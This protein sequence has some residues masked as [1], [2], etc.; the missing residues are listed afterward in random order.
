MHEKIKDGTRLGSVIVLSSILLFSQPDLSQAQSPNQEATGEAAEPDLQNLVTDEMGID[1]R[2]EA[3]EN[4]TNVSIPVGSLDDLTRALVSL[5]E[6]MKKRNDN[7]KFSIEKALGIVI[8]VL[9]AFLGAVL[10]FLA[11]Q[12]TEKRNWIRS[13]NHAR[14][15]RQFASTASAARKIREA[16]SSVHG[17]DIELGIISDSSS[18]TQV[19]KQANSIELQ[20]RQKQWASQIG[21]VISSIDLTSVELRL[22]DVPSAIC[23][24]LGEFSDRLSLVLQEVRRSP[25]EDF[26]EYAK[27]MRYQVRELETSADNFV[28]AARQLHRGMYE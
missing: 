1:D 10:T 7:A 6:Q 19:E 15:D 21:E 14:R 26:E 13:Q 27:S 23:S 8:P 25:G 17:I 9:A 2:P 16:L 4:A 28:S 20:K 24:N 12:Y 22:L 18:K 3:D 11:T 5:V